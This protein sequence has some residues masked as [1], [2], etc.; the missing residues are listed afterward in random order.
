MRWARSASV[1]ALTACSAGLA[2]VTGGGHRAPVLLLVALTVV[3]TPM[4][5]ALSGRRWRLG[6][7]IAVMGFTQLALH[8]AMSMSMPTAS[9]TMSHAAGAQAVSSHGT[10][11]MMAAT[12]VGV[13][14]AFA[15][16]L[17]YGER[18]LAWTLRV[19]VPALAASPFGL[20]RVRRGAFDAIRAPRLVDLRAPRASRAPPAS[21]VLSH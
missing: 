10:S 12:H 7:L 20:F 6:Q 9:M 16:A 19:F 21:F 18:L 1:A 14:V 4:M 2:H 15:A 17:A 13:T 8:I 3:G 11:L 5:F